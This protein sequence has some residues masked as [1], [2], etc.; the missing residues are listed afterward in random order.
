M[1]IRINLKDGSQFTI[2]G[3]DDLNFP[4]FVASLRESGRWLTSSIYIPH[5]NI[6]MI[7]ALGDDDKPRFNPD[8]GTL[9]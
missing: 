4:L 6:S 7:V 1:K 8:W 3:P 5:D 9:Q 2:D